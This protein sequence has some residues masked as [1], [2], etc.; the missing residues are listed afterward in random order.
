MP[1]VRASVDHDITVV[2]HLDLKLRPA[3]TVAAS[4]VCRGVVVILFEC[5]PVFHVQ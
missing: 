4:E 3:T 1:S 5:L 2:K